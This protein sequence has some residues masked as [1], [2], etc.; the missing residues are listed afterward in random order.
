MRIYYYRFVEK[1]ENTIKSMIDRGWSLKMPK[2]IQKM[3]VKF[4]CTVVMR[5]K[6][7]LYH[8]IIL[9]GELVRKLQGIIKG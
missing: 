8:R 9:E 5:M 6:R 7:T 4:D 2:Y 1:K 3:S